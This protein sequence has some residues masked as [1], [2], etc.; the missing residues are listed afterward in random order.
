MLEYA[1]ALAVDVLWGISLCSTQGNYATV[2]SAI[3]AIVSLAGIISLCSSFWSNCRVSSN[4]KATAELLQLAVEV[5]RVA[6]KL[7]QLSLKSWI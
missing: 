6:L 1:V 2:G 5:T 3:V 4:F 7:S